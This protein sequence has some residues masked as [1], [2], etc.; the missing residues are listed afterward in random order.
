METSSIK[1]SREAKVGIVVTLCLIVFY[2]GFNYLKGKNLFSRSRTYYAVFDNVDQLLPSATVQLNGFK[3]G[4][5]D[6]IYFAPNSYRIVVKFL[7]TE[8]NIQIPKNSE[9]HISSDL[10]GVRTLSLQLGN[11]KKF[12]ESGDTLIAVR[13]AG[14]TDEIKNALT[15]LKKQVENLAGSIDTV[16]HGFNNVFNR[17]T[18]TG[19]MSTFESMNNSM[20]NLEHAIEQTDL[21]VTSERERLGDIFENVKSITENLQKNNEKLNNIFSNLDQIT[22]DVAKSNVKETMQQLQQSVS[23]LNSVLGGIE[24]GEGSLGQLAKN[25]SLYVN[26]ETSTKNL[27]LL[28]QDLKENPQRYVHVSVFGKK[29][30]SRKK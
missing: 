19:L 8:N 28:L 14:I 16:L 4:I 30:K 20:R 25:D 18:Q 23:Q 3:I 1:I 24:R 22:D 10:L 17:K 26:L 5:V 12:A 9:A 21:L 29:D 7:I 2:I 6:Q 13:E 27:S 15:P 11:D